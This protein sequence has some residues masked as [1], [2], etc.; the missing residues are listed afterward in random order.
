MTRRPSADRPAPTLNRLSEAERDE[1]VATCNT[2]E[3]ASL[4]PSQIVPQAG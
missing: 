1:I 4:P 2:P 3:F